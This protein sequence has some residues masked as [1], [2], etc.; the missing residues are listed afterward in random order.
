[1]IDRPKWTWASLKPGTT[2]CPLDV[3]DLGAG[4]GSAAR[5]G[6][7]VAGVGELAVDDGERR[8][9]RLRGGERE[10]VGVGNNHGQHGG[11]HERASV[12]LNQRGRVANTIVF[13]TR[14]R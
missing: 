1:M 6:F 8:G 11:E 7:V 4:A 14:P 10:R 12:A 9:H 3:D 2:V 5:G 13:A